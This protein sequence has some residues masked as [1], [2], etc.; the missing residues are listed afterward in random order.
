MAMVCISAVPCMMMLTLVNSWIQGDRDTSVQV[1]FIHLFIYTSYFD[2][3]SLFVY[4]CI[5]ILTNQ[6]YFFFIWISHLYYSL[7]ILIF[8]L[9]NSIAFMFFYPFISTLIISIIYD[10]SHKIVKTIKSSITD[11]KIRE[12]KFWGLK[13]YLLNIATIK[14][15]FYLKFN[16]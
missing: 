6:P 13:H 1:I 4:M 2:P 14:T 10:L 11:W 9:K 16:C 7:L 5:D 15:T 3:S 12:F 8:I